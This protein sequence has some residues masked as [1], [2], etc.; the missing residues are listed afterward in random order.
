[1]LFLFYLDIRNFSRLLNTIFFF[2]I[3]FLF[4]ILSLVQSAPSITE[5]IFGDQRIYHQISWYI[6]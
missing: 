1:M 5:G 4:A 2:F 6:T 3:N